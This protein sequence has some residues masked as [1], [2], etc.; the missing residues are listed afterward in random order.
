MSSY[1]VD[2]PCVLLLSL[3][4]GAEWTETLSNMHQMQVEIAV[5]IVIPSV[6]PRGKVERTENHLTMEAL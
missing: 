5:V 6:K 3:H 2:C 1:A 4:T